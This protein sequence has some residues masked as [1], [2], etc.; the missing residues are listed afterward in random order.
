MTYLITALAVPRCCRLAK[1]AGR[2]GRGEQV[3]D[4]LCDTVDPR[5]PKGK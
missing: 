4:C 3:S 5:G 1:G 2:E